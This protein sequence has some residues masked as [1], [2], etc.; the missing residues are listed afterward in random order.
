MSYNYT[1]A[2]K[3]RT[4][5]LLFTDIEIR[6][7]IPNVNKIHQYYNNTSQIMH[8][9]LFYSNKPEDK[10]DYATQQPKI[11]TF[12]NGQLKTPHL[13]K[14]FSQKFEKSIPK[15]LLNKQP[16]SKHTSS[17]NVNIALG[18]KNYMMKSYRKLSSTILYLK[19]GNT[20]KSAKRYLLDLCNSL[21]L[22]TNLRKNAFSKK[23]P[24]AKNKKI[25]KSIKKP[26]K[27]M[28]MCESNCSKNLLKKTP[29]SL[30][31]FQI[32]VFGY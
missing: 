15:L 7:K 32:I 12:R 29:R 6:S 4:N 19:V 2:N 28:K 22:K 25:T 9:E 1:L 10:N 20:K 16:K 3:I 21:I 14:L 13:E 11:N 18:N 31:S 8:E 24:L 26:R 5:L 30:D 23:S 27:I 17:R